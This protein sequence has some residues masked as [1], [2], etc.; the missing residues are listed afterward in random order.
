[1]Q[2]HGMM[3][4]SRE[5]N[6]P[7]SPLADGTTMALIW[8]Q[9]GSKDQIAYLSHARPIAQVDDLAAVQ[10]GK[11]HTLTPPVRGAENRLSTR[12]RRG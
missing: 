12:R 6:M 5:E 9:A 8:P 4:P 7:N 11:P 3:Q 2:L 1:M 10:L